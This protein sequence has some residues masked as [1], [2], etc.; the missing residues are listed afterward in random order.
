MTPNQIAGA[1][2]GERSWFAILDSGFWIP[3]FRVA[4]LWIKPFPAL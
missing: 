1:N 2:A 3:L 4:Q